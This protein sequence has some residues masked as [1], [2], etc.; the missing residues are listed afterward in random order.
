MARF[1]RRPG[2]LSRL[3]FI[4]LI[5]LFAAC[6]LVRPRES[7]RR[8]EI[9]RIPLLAHSI[10]TQA[11]EPGR[12]LA[13]IAPRPTQMPVVATQVYRSPTAILLASNTP[14]PASIYIGDPLPNS[15]IRG[16]KPIFG[17]AT[18]PSFLQYR[19]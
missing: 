15:L 14:F 2:K 5:V 1:A 9:T 3:F 13:T 7:I 6:N 18:H 19:T 4:L 17:S 11:A 8:V 16:S 12:D 10:P